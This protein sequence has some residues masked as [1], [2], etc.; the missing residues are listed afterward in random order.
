MLER[1]R[2]VDHP[3]LGFCFRL[4]GQI[5][6]LVLE[7]QTLFG[8]LQVERLELE[9]P[10]L[11]FPVD[12]AAG[13]ERF[14]RRRTRLAV[15]SLRID[16]RDLD[17]LIAGQGPLL[18]ELG[19]DQLRVHCDDGYLAVSGRV[20]D[21]EQVADITFRVYLTAAAEPRLGLR[22]IVGE[23]RL[24]GFLPTPAPVVAHQLLAGLL[25]GGT[26]DGDATG[27]GDVT[28]TPLDGLLWHTLPAAG[29]RLP[30][31]TGVE[32]VAA[33]V[34]RGS[35]QV[36]YAAGPPSARATLDDDART[37]GH[38]LERFAATDSL[39]AHM[40][41]DGALRAFRG[42][43]AA[44]GPDQPFVVER[45]LAIT[46]SQP[47]LF[48]DA[49]ELARQTLGRTPDAP[50][51][52]AALAT[53]AV[54]QGD[55]RE[56][57][58]RFRILAELS[59]DDHA[60]ARAALAGARLLRSV[61]PA[62]STPLYEMVLERYPAHAEAAEA[63]S[64][65]YATESRWH[66]LVRLIRG[67][68]AGTTDQ[69]RRARDH[70]RLAQILGERLGDHA[71]AKSELEQA[72][73][74]DPEL[75]GGFEALAEVQISLGEATQAMRS[76]DTAASRY[77]D[78]GDPR[79]EARAHTRAAE[80]WRE[81]GDPTRAEERFQR[82]LELAPGQLEPLRGAA[83]LAEA[84]GDFDRA[85]AL[86]NRVIE[87]GP[88]PSEELALY[89]CELGRSLLDAGDPEAALPALTRAAELGSPA[90][91][92][93]A[94][95]L[96][97]ERHR[98]GGDVAAA[99]AELDAAVDTLIAASEH[100]PLS[101]DDQRDPFEAL[102]A[103]TQGCSQPDAEIYLSAARLALDR[104]LL[105]SADGPPSVADYRRAHALAGTL[106]RDIASRAARALADEAADRHDYPDQRRWLDAQLEVAE[107]DR[108]RVDLLLSRARLVT[109]QATSDDT[110][111]IT[112]ALADV[113]HALSDQPDDRQRVDALGLKARI[114]AAAEDRGGQAGAL[115]QRARLIDAPD[116]RMAAETEAAAAWL[117]AEN[118]DDALAAAHRAVDLADQL[119]GEAPAEV[120]REARAILGEA[121]W[122]R[123]EW[124]EVDRAYAETADDPAWPSDQRA[125][126]SYRLAVA[127][128]ERS[129]VEGAM[130]ALRRAVAEPDAPG[131]VRG[132]SYRLLAN[133]CQRL[134]QPIAAAEALE[135]LADDPDAEIS[136]GARADAWYRAGEIYRQHPERA[137]DAERCLEAALRVVGD[138]L[139]ALDALERLKRH[140]ED[141]ERVAVILGRKIAATARH[142][143]R[144]KALLA[145][146]AALQDERLGRGDVARETYRRALEIDPDFRPALRFAGADAER[147]GQLDRAVDI[148][149]RLA[150]ELP[151]DASLADDAADLRDERAEALAALDRL[152]RRRDDP[153]A[154]AA[155]LA[156]RAELAQ[157]QGDERAARRFLD[158][159][160][161]LSARAEVPEQLRDQAAETRAELEGRRH[162]AEEQLAL[163]KKHQRMG[164]DADAIAVLE[165][166]REAELL[167]DDGAMLLFA[168][169]RERERKTE[170][171]GSLERRAA[172]VA[173]KAALARLRKALRFYEHAL[174]DAEAAARVRAR[175]TEL[176]GGAGE[177]EEEEEEAEA[178]PGTSTGAGTG[179]EAEAGTG[180]EAEAEAEAEPG[181][182]IAARF[183]RNA[184]EA[185]ARDD[186]LTAAGQLAEAV[187]ARARAATT[188]GVEPGPGLRLGLDRLREVGRRGRHFEELVAGLLA[189]SAAEL[190]HE[191]S[192]A[193]LREAGAVQRAQLGDATGAADSLAR[194]LAATP[195][196]GQL[197][198]DLD[199]LLRETGDV[200]H[201]QAA[202]ELHL[203]AVAGP[204]RAEPLFQLAL[205]HS[206]VFHEAERAGF[207]LA[208]AHAADP[209]HS[210]TWL[211]LARHLDSTGA[212]EH[213]SDLYRR[214]L[215][216]LDPAP[217]LRTELTTRLD[218]IAE[219]LPQRAP[220]QELRIGE[221]MASRG[222]HEAAITHYED[223]AAAAP[224]DRR[225][226]DALV[227]LYTEIDDPDGL[228]DALVRLVAL[229]ED[230]LERAEL[231]QK[232]ARLCRER[233]HDEAETY[234]CLKEAHANAPENG[235]I[236]NR[237]RS[238]AMA[239]GEWALAAELIYAEISAA[240]T[241]REKGAL[242]F[243]LALVYDEKL[244]DAEQARVNYEQALELDPEIPAAPQPLA[245]LYELVMRHEDA[246]RMAELAAERSDSD[247]E[248]GQLWRQAAR[249]AERAGLG[250]DA[251]RLY[252]LSAM[253]AA[254]DDSQAAQAALA[255]LSGGPDDAA[256]Q[257]ELLELRLREAGE[258][259]QQVD[260]LHQ[261]LDLAAAD[262]DHE[263]IR[264][265]ARALLVA[266]PTDSSAY[267]ALKGMA[268]ADRDW[269]ALAELVDRRAAAIEDRPE[270]AARYYELGRI[271]LDQIGDLSAAL[272]AFEQA[273][274]ADPTH[275]SALEALA[276]IAYQKSDW[277]HARELYAQLRP[278]TCSLSADA[279][280]FRRG[281]IAEALG[282]D[283]AA[284][285]AFRAASEAAPG[286]R[287]AL[288]AIARTAQ[289]LGDLATA[290]AATRELIDQLPADA[291]QPMT[292]A[293]F[294]LAELYRQVGDTAAAI[295]NYERVLSEAPK[296]ADALRA[297]VELYRDQG[298]PRD[299][300][301]LLRELM[302]LAPTPAQHA[303]LLFQ[304]GELFLLHLGDPERAAD[305]FLKAIDLA[306]NHVPTLRR[307]VD[308]YWT[309]DD[310]DSL[311]EIAGDLIRL[312]AIAGSPLGAKVR[313]VLAAVLAG[314]AKLAAELRGDITE[315]I[316][317]EVA[318][319]L[320]EAASRKSD[321]EHL[322]SAAQTL[323]RAIDGL[324]LSE[325]FAQVAARAPDSDLANS[326]LEL[327]NR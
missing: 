234:R 243:E 154:L 263:A 177:E 219:L 65:R 53:V 126:F 7:E 67:R 240:T 6:K 229:T 82:A 170:L 68:M 4:T 312:D 40:D 302:A 290:I 107:D 84:R 207:Y 70:L 265:H 161:S 230:R 127:R 278:E 139:P 121:A 275:P 253:T 218:A 60:A 210:A 209:E 62:E 239:H 17:R 120:A 28:V 212:L 134:D 35:I 172:Y 99:A 282:D 303:E 47:R 254:D 324:A 11:A 317:N 125:T 10:D 252:N 138:H 306:P 66:D 96:L 268:E 46:T 260:I 247:L 298:R 266:D 184:A 159:I 109:E 92:A 166:A 106:D 39:L 91:A 64:D 19:V 58:T 307:L 43:L 51:A 248:R 236:A 50:A 129:D 42:E 37:L 196:D 222:Q 288:G 167:G 104:A 145:R 111:A 310:H 18:A 119:A 123:R 128:V 45:L 168:L 176:E 228:S 301:N 152:H 202:Y 193:L 105:L 291:V 108:T 286:D 185:L 8:W 73:A 235:D 32:L 250:D 175:L 200:S 110:E 271:Y 241:P 224:A 142:P 187:I 24:Y 284:L 269:L 181:E 124:N 314:R 267:L 311:L 319:L 31:N 251:R 203:Q 188:A 153:T 197:L 261:L 325:V 195:T 304:Q 169:Y 76:L 101:D 194:A 256:G 86:W 148:Y 242:H 198:A 136:E 272:N 83:A 23:P 225:P 283:R 223:A 141:Y 3:P 189:A 2:E 137:G 315:P 160:A 88:H 174:G 85:I 87:A 316:A 246:M 57:A 208:A 296:S 130:A 150:T 192:A 238:I 52:H 215:D 29:W 221:E 320:V 55:P 54:A 273:L 211:P 26:L 133:L 245:R 117:A 232:R 155:V 295:D 299:V 98:S 279:L 220:L 20:R 264:R 34:R 305:V 162:Q 287:K 21:K 255:R 216:E 323:C 114:F 180:R 9:V 132:S 25:C 257:R 199:S 14:Q 77:A 140:S 144:Q 116:E 75:A 309:V 165:S 270:R 201:L 80:L 293:R 206:D 93:R 227:R 191:R 205:L 233:L 149:E 33:R 48:V 158:E 308:Y 41:L 214:V 63:L 300:A 237:L 182:A 259:D 78:K 74:L 178:E 285:D 217:D 49:I 163:A 79:G 72:C 15:A 131:E 313:I 179:A 44:G 5:G 100:G 156:R 103:R 321:P 294:R 164:R 322:A 90:T 173:P 143:N 190:D 326:I 151:D 171:A 183:E 147:A 204:A 27:L 61:A 89:S 71:A 118:H 262:E 81:L 274:G 56:A 112:A 16:Q 318:A 281:E 249:N 297:L 135:A 157:N 292:T 97:A 146:L 12:L 1:D 69:T 95:Q 231:W 13:P 115:D 276:A 277:G 38:N 244:L 102:A 280:A 36:S 30:S 186:S 327:L 122:R 94:H 258:L 213:A 226:L 289:R 22:L 113:E 59:T